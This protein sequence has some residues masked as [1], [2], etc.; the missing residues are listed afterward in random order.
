MQVYHA[1]DQTLDADTFLS[2]L[3]ADY[4]GVFLTNCIIEGDIVF[5]TESSE[6]SVVDKE[7]VCIGSTFKGSVKFEKNRFS[8]RG[9]FR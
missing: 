2:I 3:Q 4:E 6:Q 5:S 7:I 8:E 9:L 1:T